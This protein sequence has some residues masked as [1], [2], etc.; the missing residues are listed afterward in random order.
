MTKKLLIIFGVIIL[1]V[2]I[3]VNY[4]VAAGIGSAGVGLQDA[5]TKSNLSGDFSSTISTVVSAI[6]AIVGTIFLIM[7]IYAGMLWLTASGNSER[8]DKGKRILTESVIGLVIALSAYAIT[9]FVG[10]RLGASDPKGGSEQTCADKKGSCK[11]SCASDDSEFDV[12]TTDCAK[13]QRVCCINVDECDLSGNC[14]Q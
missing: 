3:G 14:N 12:V 6:L 2:L 7:M 10:S 8:S 11:E 9:N 1:L 13:Q 4:S 5:G